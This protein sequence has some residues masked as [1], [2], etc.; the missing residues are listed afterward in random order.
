MIM[1]SQLLVR[2][3]SLVALLALSAASP[4]LAQQPAAAAPDSDTAVWITL[5][6]G[7]GP[8][9]RVRRA[10]PANALV[11]GGE[12]ILF[13]A[14]EGVIQGL[15]RAGLRLDQVSTVVISHLHPDHIAGLSA[16]IALRWHVSATSPLVIAGPPGTSELVDGIIASLKP[17]EATKSPDEK[18]SPSTANWVAARVIACDGTSQMIGRVQIKA[19][20]NSHYS[21]RD[22]TDSKTATSCS[23]RIEAGERSIVYTGDTGPSPAVTALARHAELLVSEVMDLDAALANVDRQSAYL[24]AEQREGVN[25]H[26]KAHHLTAEQVGVLAQEAEV[27]QVVLTHLVPGDDGETTTAG[28]TAGIANTF[29]GKVIVAEDG[30]RF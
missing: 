23:F 30:Y 12:V 6:T 16:L 22:G 15:A 28:Y 26:L 9:L 17:V 27:G 14:G 8:I 13:D 7:G 25:W 20:R 18:P 11:L 29:R 4:V 5:G 24:T 3:A 1:R 19:V 21:L 10:G 2:L